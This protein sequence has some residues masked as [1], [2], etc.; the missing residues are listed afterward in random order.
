MAA[1][2]LDVEREPV[3]ALRAHGRAAAENLL[4]SIA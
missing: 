3:A 1:L 4:R 2:S